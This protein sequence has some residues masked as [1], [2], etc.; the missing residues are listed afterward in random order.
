MQSEYVYPAIASRLSPK[1]W[2]EMQK[3]DIVAE[4]GKRKNQ[5]LASHYPSY[6][7]ESIDNTLRQRF[8]ICLPKA[9]MRAG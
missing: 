5:I 6:I 9:A 7:P 2:E 1:E 8:N 3:P 4:A